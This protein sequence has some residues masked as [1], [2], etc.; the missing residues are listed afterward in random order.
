[1]NLETENEIIQVI[2]TND[3]LHTFAAYSR[4]HDEIMKYP[5]SY[6]CGITSN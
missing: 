3:K 6:Q 1:M 2:T 4:K 5:Y